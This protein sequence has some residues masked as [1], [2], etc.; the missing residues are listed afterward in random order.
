MYL[1]PFYSSPTHGRGRWTKTLG[2]ISSSSSE[3]EEREIGGGQVQQNVLKLT[4][5]ENVGGIRAAA[6]SNNPLLAMS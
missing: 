2:D 6:D 1:S 3:K 5:A 4:P